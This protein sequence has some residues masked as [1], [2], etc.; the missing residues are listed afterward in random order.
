[1][2]AQEEAV[3]DQLASILQAE[4][5]R[6]Y[7]A[8]LFA[9][10][11]G[12]YDPLVRRAA[13]LA[14]GRIGDPATLEHL[15]VLLADPD[16]TVQTAAAFALGLLGDSTAVGPLWDF[17]EGAGNAAPE[18]VAEAVTALAKLGSAGHLATLIERNGMALARSD[19]P[20]EAIRAVAESWRLG[21]DAPLDALTQTATS[22]N[23]TARRWAV[24]SLSRLRA[25]AAAGLFMAALDDDD[26][27]VR[28]YAA[29][30]LSGAY[31]DTAGLDRDAVADRLA[32]MVDDD[33]AGVRA[34]ALRAL[35]GFRTERHAGAVQDRL[36]DRD[37]NVRVQALET[38]GRLGGERAADALARQV[39]RG[40]PA[41]RQ[42]ALW[43]LASA[44]RT[45]GIAEAARWIT[46]GEWRRRADGATALGILGGD[47]A[48]A[49][50]ES[51]L[52]DPDGRVAAR[53]FGA[54]G[55]V[56]SAHAHL[57]AGEM[58]TH[59]DVVVR[60]LAAGV[61]GD[62]P[63]TADVEPLVAAYE[64]AQADRENDA[65][66][67][68][69]R[70]L[71]RIA[72]LGPIQRTVVERAL[73]ARFPSSDEYLVRRA[74]AEHLPGVAARWGPAFPV[75]TERDIQD[76]RDI[77]RGLQLPAARGERLP[78]RVIDSDRGRIEIELFAADAP[79]TVNHLLELVDRRY[80]DA[81]VWHRVVPNF[82]IQD[83]DPRGD[84]WGGPG[85]AIRDEINPRR[86][87]T[88]TVGMA[89]SG[90]DTGGSQFFITHAPQ[91]HLD[92]GYTVFGR[93]TR[94]MEAVRRI[95][96]GDRIRTVR[97]R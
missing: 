73:L 19:A 26:P 40:S 81:G 5:A 12:H 61:L 29:R 51:L 8:P 43:S 20:N 2:A 64:A 68:V 69:I 63:S 17:I 1:V 45:R 50:L 67:A 94:G 97:R 87:E 77:V 39:T 92:G 74:V 86:Y 82:V 85:W 54:L 52:D 13:A 31:A 21:P 30:T 70:T 48:D 96:Q 65:R 93:V 78:R 57:L 41:E 9:P 72:A 27:L 33:D 37:P 58:L 79:M 16:T 55:R 10:G 32:R 56:D 59:D 66:L 76:Y 15:R 36:S 38:L 3:V 25:P 23:P 35:A 44:D 47:T 53:A 71:G 22:G 84:G 11:V 7:E 18:A 89:L 4:D 80:F 91:P 6:R 14:M 88:G 75:E 90:P 62:A 83:G 28:A 46:D 60:T 95:T 34:N 24:Y 49:W 42:R